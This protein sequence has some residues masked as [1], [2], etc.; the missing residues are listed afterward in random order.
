MSETEQ[1]ERKDRREV[2]ETRQES[3]IAKTVRGELR[4]K[5]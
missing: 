4:V 5:K 1:V 2:Q 3:R